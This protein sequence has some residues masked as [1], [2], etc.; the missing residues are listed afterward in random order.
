MLITFPYFINRIA[1]IIKGDC[2]IRFAVD[3]DIISLF[4]DLKTMALHFVPPIFMNKVA[5]VMD[6]LLSL[7]IVVVII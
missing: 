2:A 4:L 5:L 6:N 7:C 1:P 3:I